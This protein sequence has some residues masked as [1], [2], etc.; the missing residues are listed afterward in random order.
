MFS[1]IQKWLERR[2]AQKEGQL[3]EAIL[4]SRDTCARCGGEVGDDSCL[5]DVGVIEVC[6]SQYCG[7]ELVDEYMAEQVA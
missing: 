4:M 1:I 6:C 5:V 3:A 2:S 7:G